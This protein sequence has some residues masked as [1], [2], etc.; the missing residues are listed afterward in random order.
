MF[1]AIL[2]AINVP[3]NEQRMKALAE[4]IQSSD[5]KSFTTSQVRV[6]ISSV[7]KL[8][9]LSNT[10][11]DKASYSSGKIA[12]WRAFSDLILTCPQHCNTKN[13]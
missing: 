8:L 13:F 2:A 9:L 10:S 12:L 3:N 6:V 4:A 7:D 11:N 1:P 5:I